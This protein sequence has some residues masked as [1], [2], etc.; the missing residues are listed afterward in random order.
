MSGI[1]KYLGRSFLALAAIAFSPITSFGQI[2]ACPSP[3]SPGTGTLTNDKGDSLQFAQIVGVNNGQRTPGDLVLNYC[4]SDPR[5]QTKFLTTSSTGWVDYY[6]PIASL[7]SIEF[8]D[9][10][11]KR[12]FKVT[13]NTGD[14]ESFTCQSFPTFDVFVLPTPLVAVRVTAPWKY[15]L[16]FD[17]SPSEAGPVGSTTPV[18]ALVPDVRLSRNPPATPNHVDSPSRAANSTSTPARQ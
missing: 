5:W 16:A 8:P 3:G 4:I 6:L 9:V 15:R 1:L 13:Y 2:A 18:H 14:T 10:L 12:I 11:D 7:K 17:A